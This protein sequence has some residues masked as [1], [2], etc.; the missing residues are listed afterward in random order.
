MAGRVHEKDRVGCATTIGA[1]EGVVR[2]LHGSTARVETDA[3]DTFEVHVND[4][5]PIEQ[6]PERHAESPIEIRFELWPRVAVAMVAM[7]DLLIYQCLENRRKE[8]RMLF[9]TD[10][11]DAPEKGCIGRGGE[12]LHMHASPEFLYF[13][14]HKDLCLTVEAYNVVLASGNKGIPAVPLLALLKKYLEESDWKPETDCGWYAYVR[15]DASGD[16]SLS[17]RMYG[18][19]TKTIRV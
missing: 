10:G 13:K 19:H 2:W 9:T 14:S 7:I 16:L 6:M 18:T 17:W 5:W 3:G 4:V 11:P 1:Q 12:L 8:V 15:Q